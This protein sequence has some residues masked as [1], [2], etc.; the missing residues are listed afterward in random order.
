[1]GDHAQPDGHNTMATS[2]IL[3]GGP[4]LYLLSSSIYKSLVFGRFPLSHIGGLVALAVVAFATYRPV[5]GRRAW[6]G[7]H[8]GFTEWETFSRRAMSAN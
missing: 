7:D 8:A 4:L 6:H 1:M 5:D 2:C 3:I